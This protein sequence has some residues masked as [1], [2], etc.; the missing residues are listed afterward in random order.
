MTAMVERVKEMQ[1][2]EAVAKAIFWEMN[3]VMHD[4]ADAWKQCDKKVV[5]RDCARAALSAALHF[6]D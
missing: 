5:Y 1:K 4:H 3:A 2:L 6:P